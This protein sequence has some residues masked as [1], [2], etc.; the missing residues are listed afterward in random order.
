MEGH[1]QKCVERYGELA[2]KVE[3]LQSFSKSLLGRPSFQT[4][5]T[6]ISWRS[7]TCLLTN[8]LEMLVLGTILDDLT[9]YGRSTSLPDQSRNGLWHVTTSKIDISHSS[10]KRCPTVFVMRDT[11]H[12]PPS[13]APCLIDQQFHEF[14]RSLLSLL[15]FGSRVVPNCL[16]SWC[17]TVSAKFCDRFLRHALAFALSRF[18]VP[19]SWHMA[20][21]EQLRQLAAQA[22]LACLEDVITHGLQSLLES[23]SRLVA[24][25][26]SVEQVQ[27]AARL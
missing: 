9:L 22:S 18:C 10:H 24:P 20:R 17:L 15:S 2:N 21:S 14:G 6:R 4:R 5:G 26:S 12:V 25:V 23:P 19:V 1:A 27:P 3:Q 13:H 16:L 7:V 8:C 11:V